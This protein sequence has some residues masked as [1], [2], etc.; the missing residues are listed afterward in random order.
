[1]S[2]RRSNRESVDTFKGLVRAKMNALAVDAID[3]MNLRDGEAI[4][5]YALETTD[6]L[7]PHGRPH[8]AQGARYMSVHAGSILTVGGNN[9]IDRI[10]SAGLG[11]VNDHPDRDDPR[12]RQPLVVDKIPG[13]PD[14]TF[15][16]E[17]LDVSTDVMAWLTGKVGALAEPAGAPGAAD[18]PAPSTSGRTAATSTSSRRGRTRSRRRRR[19]RR[20]PPDPRLLPDARQLPLRRHR[21]RHADR[22]ARRR[23][24]LLRRPPPVE[25]YAPATAPSRR[26]SRPTRP[27]STASAAAPAPRSATSS[28]SSSAEA[29]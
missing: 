21:L 24:V 22:R 25:E 15:T 4:N 19:H 1:L 5:G 23:R 2:R 26:S 28:A 20:R 27:C 18:P 17:S 10:Q 12:G 16:M 29:A 13:E 9:V 8:S 11:D 7:Y 3:V 14:F 6:R